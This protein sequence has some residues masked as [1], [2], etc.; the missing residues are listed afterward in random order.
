MDNESGTDTDT[1]TTSSSSIVSIS[2][3]IPSSSSSSSMDSFS[4]ITPPVS[5]STIERRQREN[6]C[7]EPPA[8]KRKRDEDRNIQHHQVSSVMRPSVSTNVSVSSGMNVPHLDCHSHHPSRRNKRRITLTRRNR[9]VSNR[10]LLL[11]QQD[12]GPLP[13]LS[14]T[15]F[16][17]APPLPSSNSNSNHNDDDGSGRETL[18]VFT[19][20]PRT[21]ARSKQDHNATTS[22][23]NRWD[24]GLF[25]KQQQQ[26]Q[27]QD[28]NSL[29]LPPPPTNGAP[30]A[31][32]VSTSGSN[33]SQKKDHVTA[34][35]SSPPPPPPP[36]SSSSKAVQE[37]LQ[38][39]RSA[40]IGIDLGDD[41][42]AAAAVAIHAMST[43]LPSKKITTALASNNGCTSSSINSTTTTNSFLTLSLSKARLSFGGLGSSSSSN[44]HHNR[45]SHNSY[46]TPNCCTK[47][48]IQNLEG[49]CLPSLEDAGA[50]S[51][52]S[53]NNNNNSNNNN[54]PGN[55]TRSC[56]Q[57]KRPPST[58]HQAYGMMTTA[59]AT[60]VAIHPPPPPP[61]NNGNRGIASTTFDYLAT[62]LRL[63]DVAFQGGCM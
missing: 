44:S 29:L 3:H 13:M 5:P 37:P 18:P 16:S 22:F 9:F 45:N 1:T 57:Q 4:L 12:A 20:K 63:P 28:E 53:S 25:H 6:L 59:A 7:L 31:S 21:T 32:A 43:P 50:W 36:L 34:M 17:S 35:S 19:L 61:Q 39:C 33:A 46:Q 54:Y 41:G 23:Q 52:S 49:L 11:L 2:F 14:V 48:L 55:G 58:P 62:A 26:Q 24:E 60:T 38:R 30:T 27:Q 40:S 10:P 47:T 42:A 56:L 51:S 15:D 8:L